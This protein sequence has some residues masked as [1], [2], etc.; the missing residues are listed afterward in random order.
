MTSKKLVEGGLSVFLLM[1]GLPS[2]SMGESFLGP[3]DG[4]KLKKEKSSWGMECQHCTPWMSDGV[5]R[6]IPN[7]LPGDIL[8][9]SG[10]FGS[11]SIRF[12]LARP[13][14]KYGIKWPKGSTFTTSGMDAEIISVDFPEE[15]RIKGVPGKRFEFSNFG[16][17]HLESVKITGDFSSGGY[18]WPG[19][20]VLGFA[21]PVGHEDQKLWYVELKQ[22]LVLDGK[23]YPK[24]SFVWFNVK[25]KVD[26]S[27]PMPRPLQ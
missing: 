23:E 6:C 15:Q 20:S 7:F 3:C 2:F 8:D 22:D 12:T 24:N 13:V 4:A 27:A 14:D 19:G 17:V 18:T 1:F 5:P 11:D 9:L 10:I 26:L 21:P 25:G 16:K